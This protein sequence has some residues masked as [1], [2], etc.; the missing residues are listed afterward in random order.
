MVE[1]SAPI[2][3]IVSILVTDKGEATTRPRPLPGITARPGYRAPVTHSTVHPTDSDIVVR[4]AGR[5]EGHHVRRLLSHAD[6]AHPDN[7]AG[8]VDLVRQG[9][10]SHP[11]WSPAYTMVAADRG[12][13][14]LGAIMAGPL[15]KWLLGLV[16]QHRLTFEQAGELSPTLMAI[17]AIGVDPHARRR[18]VGTKLMSAMEDHLRDR[19]CYGVLL[20]YEPIVPGLADFYSALGYSLCPSDQE[21]ILS[22][23]PVG[24]VSYRPNSGYNTAVK[25][26]HE[27]AREIEPGLDATTA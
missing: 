25:A 10:G 12:G 14:L 6:P 3:P 21:I 8:V 24:E 7:F 4:L 18:G 5:H 19:G 9:G 27:L 22:L 20:D 1:N 17:A 15:V 2:A 16:K 11:G 13:R 23:D 26:L